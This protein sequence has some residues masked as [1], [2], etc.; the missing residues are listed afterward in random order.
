[1]AGLGIIIPRSGGSG[2]SLEID[3]MLNA[4]SLLLVDPNHYAKPWSAGVPAHLSQIPNLASAKVAQLLGA[5]AVE[6]GVG[7]H[8][9]F[10]LGG[11]INNGTKGLVERTSKGALHGIVSQSVALASGDG[12]N[13]T[14]HPDLRAY[15]AANQSHRYYVSQWDRLTRA[16]AGSMPGSAAQFTGVSA[17]STSSTLLAL[18]RTDSIYQGGGGFISDPNAFVATPGLNSAGDRFIACGP[19]TDQT[20]VVGQTVF[21]G[22]MWGAS[23]GTYNAAVLGTR[24]TFWPSFVFRRFYLED[25]TVSGRTFA[26]ARDADLAL[27]NAAVAAGGRY[28]G[29]T[30]TSPASVA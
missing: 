11:A 30:W 17:A 18:I 3:G 27:H 16:N 1:M 23:T 22:P 8:S 10:T 26:Q 9:T 7:Y 21:A 6:P 29:D 4:G 25:L 28:G 12:V 19:T 20:I 24:N 14:I 13:M 15:L 5:P 2:P